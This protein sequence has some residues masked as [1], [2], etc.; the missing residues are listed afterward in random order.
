M[1]CHLLCTICS[2]QAILDSLIFSTCEKFDKSSFIVG[3]RLLLCKQLRNIT[4]VHILHLVI[5]IRIQKQIL[6]KV[7]S[8]E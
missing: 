6:A 7:D 2:H 5:G 8:P 3:Q 4:R 1:S